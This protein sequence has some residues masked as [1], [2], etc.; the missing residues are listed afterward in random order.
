MLRHISPRNLGLAALAALALL[1]AFANP[2]LLFVGN[3]ILIY[4]IL[5][6]GLN[7]LVGYAGLLAFMNGSLFGDRRVRARRCCGSISACRTDGASRRVR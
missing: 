2:Y 3:L 5:T 7:L 6:V 1:P 4:V